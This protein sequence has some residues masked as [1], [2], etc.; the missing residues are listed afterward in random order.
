MA[1]ARAQDRAR[2]RSAKDPAEKKGASKAKG[3]P[4]A[5]RR[6]PPPVPK[7]LYRDDLVRAFLQRQAELRRR[8]MELARLKAQL[9][10]STPAV[11]QRIREA[12]QFQTLQMQR[13]EDPDAPFDARLVLVQKQSNNTTRPMAKADWLTLATELLVEQG[14]TPDDA[15]DRVERAVEQVPR[16]RRAGGAG[17]VGGAGPAVGAWSIRVSFEDPELK[18]PAPA[19]RAG[20]ARRNAI[21]PRGLDP[22]PPPGPPAPV[23]AAPPAGAGFVQ[24]AAPPAAPLAAASLSSSSQGFVSPAVLGVM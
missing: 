12:T 24:P 19:S 22:S 21:A 17:G 4:R 2:G 3:R 5:P 8:E 10:E 15:R 23:L 9:A 13:A 20:G 7:Q 1:R 16:E 11:V 18:R 6:P 14:M